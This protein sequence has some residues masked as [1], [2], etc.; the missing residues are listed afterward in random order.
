[1]W[2][3][4]LPVQPGKPDIRPDAPRK[5]GLPRL[6]EVLGRD[7][8][9]IGKAGLLVSLALLAESLP[10]VLLA[11]AAAGWLM[12]RK[13]SAVRAEQQEAMQTVSGQFS[14]GHRNDRNSPSESPRHFAA[15][16]DESV[17]VG[18]YTS[19]RKCIPVP[20]PSAAQQKGAD[21]YSQKR[22]NRPHLCP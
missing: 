10:L 15:L 20:Q 6:A 17:I 4:S 22:R 1:M 14:S 21:L 7:L 16:R 13:T 3:N 19:R 12:F 8:G 9:S 2:F 18:Y 5:K 11:A